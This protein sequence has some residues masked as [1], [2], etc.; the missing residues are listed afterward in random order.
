MQFICRNMILWSME[1]WVG[2]HSGKWR[3][4]RWWRPGRG[5]YR[6]LLVSPWFALRNCLVLYRRILVQYFSWLSCL[7]SLYCWSCNLREAWCFRCQ[8]YWLIYI[9]S[10]AFLVR[11]LRA[12][13]RYPPAIQVWVAVPMRHKWSQHQCRLIR[14]VLGLD[15]VWLIGALHLFSG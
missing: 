8:L 4:G 2:F 5:C 10:P 9:S 6:L 15:S 13:S 7:P 1:P 12:Y 14:S 3:L 11:V